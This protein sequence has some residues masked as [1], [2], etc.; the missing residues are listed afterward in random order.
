MSVFAIAALAHSYRFLLIG[1]G[2]AKYK[3]VVPVVDDI[4][5][6]PASSVWSQLWFN[7]NEQFM[8]LFS[9][10]AH[11]TSSIIIGP[12]PAPNCARE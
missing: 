5:L 1:F 9:L 4:H 7:V 2:Y 11:L 3:F 12:A 10:P 6:T 8:R